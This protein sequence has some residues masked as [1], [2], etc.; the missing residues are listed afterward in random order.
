MRIALGLTLLALGGCA[1]SL[2]SVGMVARDADVVSVKMLVPGAVGRSCRSSVIGVPLRAGTATVDEALAEVFAR[3]GE[4]NV[5]TG[6]E[7]RSEH[8]VT[9][10]YNRHCVTVRGD[11]ARAISTVTLPMPAG[12]S[13]HH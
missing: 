12:H 8:L 5:V 3:D 2:G 10:V 13:A 6:L 11:L 9:G 4:G 1:T 7:I